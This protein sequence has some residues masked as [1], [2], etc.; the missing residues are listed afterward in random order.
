MLSGLYERSERDRVPRHVEMYREDLDAFLLTVPST[1][2]RELNL[3]H[4]VSEF[5]RLS[6][7]DT[8]SSDERLDAADVGAI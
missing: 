5:G 8:Q 4:N 3:N 2:Q 1:P 6:M 7:R